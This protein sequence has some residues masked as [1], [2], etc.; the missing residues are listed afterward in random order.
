MAVTVKV[1]EVF[2]V[3]PDTDIGEEALLPVIPP[4]FDVAVYEVI[5]ASPKSAGPVNGT[6][7]VS[8]LTVAVPIVGANGTA[9]FAINDIHALPVHT[10]NAFLSVL[11][12]RS[13]AVGDTGLLAVPP[14]VY[15]AGTVYQVVFVPSVCKTLFALPVWAGSKEFKVLVVEVCPV[16]P[17]DTGSGVWISIPFFTLKSLFAIMSSSHFQYQP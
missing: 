2:A 3:S 9:P 14:L 11:K 5:A 13:P 8:P 4:G 6:D 7:A 16:P 17:I 15:A 10:S 1:Y 12:N